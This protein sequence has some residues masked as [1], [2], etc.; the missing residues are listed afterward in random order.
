MKVSAYYNDIDPYVVQWVRNLIREELLP[1]GEVDDCPIQEI[2]ADD[3]KNFAQCH[4][5][6]G[7]GG[8]AYAL[9]LAGWGDE[10]VW[11]GSCPCQPFSGAGRKK[12]EKDERHLWPAFYE[13]IA[14]CR[15]PVI[16]GEQVASK[17]GR[18]WVTAVRLDLEDV[19]YAF[20][21][22]DLC[23]AG[24]GAPHIR[25]RLWWVADH[26]GTTGGGHSR[27]LHDA[28]VQQE[29]EI[30]NGSGGGGADGGM[31]DT[32][33][34]RR[35]NGKTENKR[36]ADRKVN[37][38]A[39][40][41]NL[42][43][44]KRVGDTE[45]ERLQRREEDTADG[46]KISPWAGSSFISCADG[47]YRPFKPGILPVADGVPGRVGQIRAYGNAIVPQV[48]TVFIQSFMDWKQTK[49]ER[50][51]HRVKIDEEEDTE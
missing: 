48:A 32:E 5:F 33:S 42:A 46:C 39:D 43:P 44:A 10:P 47:K 50:V 3:I 22:A 1:A 6:A 51:E 49:S 30:P 45:S 38:L 21:A 7:I 28:G 26:I 34:E 9:S 11:T 4:F 8:W 23:A 18:E 31:D 37:A 13:L 24:V 27:N 19:G 25:Q 20:G 12:G 15:P 14:E 29:K 35:N 2:K 17:L 40:T 36:K 41:S 16:F